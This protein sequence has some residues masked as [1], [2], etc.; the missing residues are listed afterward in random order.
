MKTKELKARADR[1][2]VTALKK[3]QTGM[4]DIY[5]NIPKA[6]LLFFTKLA[7]KMGWMVE[8]KRDILKKYIVSRPK[9]VDMSENE[10]LSEI[11]AVRYT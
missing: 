10:I 5:L 3:E 11:R 6:D 1:K 2:T 8:T 4:Q 7:E 9:N